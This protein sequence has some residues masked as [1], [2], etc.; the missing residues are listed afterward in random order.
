M[1]VTPIGPNITSQPLNDNFSDVENNINTHKA[2]TTTSDDVHGSKTYADT[3]LPLAGGTMT[4]NLI[5]D[6]F[7]VQIGKAIGAGG[8]SVRFKSDD[9]IVRWLV[10]LLGSVGSKSYSIYDIASANTRFIIN[11]SGVVTINSGDLFLNTVRLFTGSGSPEGVITAPIGSLYLRTD[12]GANT[13][14]YVKES[15]TGNTGWIAK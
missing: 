8:G 6:N 7:T 3:K 15:G 14:L 4:G 5:V 12:G 9:G 13:T 1:A 2:E 10:G 11:S